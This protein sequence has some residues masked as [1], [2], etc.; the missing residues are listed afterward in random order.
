MLMK[1]ILIICCM[2]V[3]TMACKK[4]VLPETPD[5]NVTAA[6]VTF[7]AGKEGTFEFNGTAGII[8]FYSGEA[9]REYVAGGTPDGVNKSI[10]VKGYSDSRL[11]R[12]TYTYAAKG[13]YKAYFI[14]KNTSIY[15]SREVVK[16]VTVTVTE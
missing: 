13:E 16:A 2:L 15:G 11:Q 3:L 8:A 1:R 4:E 12:F 9:G 5:F 7:A 10:S 6:A 14:G